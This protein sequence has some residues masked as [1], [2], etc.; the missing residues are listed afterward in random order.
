MNQQSVVAVYESF[1][2]AKQGLQALEEADFPRDQVSLA[3]PDQQADLSKYQDAKS[4]QLGDQSESQAAK[5]AGAGG[6]IGLLLAT[7][8]VIA[9]GGLGAVLLAGPMAMGLTGAV[10]G[11]L[12]GAMKGWG[13]HDDHIQRYE[14]RVAD[15]SALILAHGNPQ[16]VA[17]AEEILQGTEPQELTLHA[18]TSADHVDE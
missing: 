18:E 4:L 16:Q 9:S 2:K 15:G 3:L 5:G 14:Q 1:E 11:G 17:Q 12:V 13:I 7:P 10:V 8:I 6:L